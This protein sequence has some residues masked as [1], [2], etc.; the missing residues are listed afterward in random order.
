MSADT[1]QILVAFICY[2]GIMIVIGLRYAKKNETSSDFFLGGRKVGPWMTALSAEASDMSAW[3]LMGLPG[4]AYVSGMKGV[5][6]TALGLLV[7][8]Y[9]NW[10]LVA[11]RLRMYSIHAKDSIT[12]PEFFI[13]RFKDT[14]RIIGLITTIIILVFFTVYAASGFVACAK[15]FNSVYGIPYFWALCLGVAVILLYTILGGYLAVCA[16]DFIQG[17]I[18]FFALVITVTIMVISLGGPVETY[19]QIATLG[20]QFLTPFTSEGTSESFLSIL[21]NLAWGL[22]YFGMPHILVRF[23]AIR[24]NKE[25]KLSRRVAMIWVT[26]ALIAAVFVGVIGKIYLAPTVLGAGQVESVFLVSIMKM[27]PAFIA[28]IFLCGIMAAAMSTADSQLLV[29]SSAFSRDVFKSFIKKEASEKQTLFVSRITVV[30]VALIAFVIAIDPNSSI[31][32]LV[33]FAWAGFGASFA[34]IIILALFWKRITRNGAITGLLVGG[35]TAV[36]WYLLQGG[37]FDVYEILPGFLAGIISAVI[38]SLVGK[39]NPEVESE[40]DAFTKLED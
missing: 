37:I 1:I 6:W 16:T 2:L 17:M 10:L 22:G 32:G 9:L 40:F 36:I 25:I 27:F 12:L 33:S 38:V 4:V 15:V 30:V 24:S 26:I 34:P 35:V 14:S 23:M 18:M 28:G 13:N 31:F 8:T 7:G 20:T 21:G 11:K 3:L 19:Q 29:A 39:R 5:F